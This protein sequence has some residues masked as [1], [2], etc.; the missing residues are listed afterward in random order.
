MSEREDKQDIAELI[1][2]W[3]F[4][5]DTGEFDSLVLDTP[6]VGQ[7]TLTFRNGTQYI[8]ETPAG[9][10]KTTPGVVAR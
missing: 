2:N 6:A 10:L 9:T 1:Q 4:W 7:H 5:R 3:A 8:F